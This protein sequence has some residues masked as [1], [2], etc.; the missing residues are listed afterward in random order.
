MNQQ[1][2]EQLSALADGELERDQIRF[3]LRRI[4]VDRD[5]GRRWMRYHLVREV[6]RRQEVMALPPDFAEKVLATL[7]MESPVATRSSVWLRWG[8]GGAIAASVAV[9]ALMVTRPADE[10]ATP[11]GFP[12]ATLARVV[13]TAPAPS[14]T[15]ATATTTSPSEFRTPLLAPNVPETAPASFGTDLAQPIALDPQMQSYLLRHYQAVGGPG[16]S[17]FVPYVLLGTPQREAATTQ[18]TESNPRHH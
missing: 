8:A 5:L 16:P 4:G 6:L 10:S 13:P 14:A 7:A 3:L 9:A 2:H 15:L 11:S 12:R 1:I 18:S 17:A